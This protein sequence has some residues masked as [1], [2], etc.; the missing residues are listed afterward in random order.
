MAIPRSIM[1]AA[2][3]VRSSYRIEILGAFAMAPPALKVEV[4]QSLYC[5]PVRIP[6][7]QPQTSTG[8]VKSNELP[9]ARA[10][11]ESAPAS[12]VAHVLVFARPG[13]GLAV[14][15][16]QTGPNRWKLPLTSNATGWMLTKPWSGI[17]YQGIRLSEQ[18]RES[19]SRM[20]FT[21]DRMR[22]WLLAPN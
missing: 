7:E 17:N 11:V 20:P 12:L 9:L 4:D 19:S 8:S 13:P 2:F 1:S 6:C 18:A 3:N 15:G 21:T 16:Y 22:E 5:R 14:T 10:P